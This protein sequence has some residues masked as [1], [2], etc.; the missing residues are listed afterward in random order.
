MQQVIS[1]AEF[2]QLVGVSE[3]RVSQLMSDGVLTKGQPFGAWLHAYLGRLRDQAAARE[4]SGTLDLVQERAALA[5]SQREAQELK[6]AS[7]RSEYAPTTVLA[8]VLGIVR[9]GLVE[10]MDELPGTLDQA[11]P[12]LPDTARQVVQQVLASARGEWLRATASLANAEG[13]EPA[14]D[15]DELAADLDDD[16]AATDD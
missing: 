9:T 13:L 10:R 1:Q 14:E 16:S 15:E 8:E 11:C 7:A 6:N 12:G 5:R 4:G 2:A 3:A